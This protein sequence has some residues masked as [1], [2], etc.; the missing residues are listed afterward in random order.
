M[1]HFPI[2]DATKMSGAKLQDPV[3]WMK[4][5][6]GLLVMVNLKRKSFDINSLP[7]SI[8]DHRPN[9]SKILNSGFHDSKS[10]ML[11]IIFLLGTQ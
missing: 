5:H 7:A 6:A 10:W 9:F 4:Q 2:P 8:P 11:K 1:D 3:K